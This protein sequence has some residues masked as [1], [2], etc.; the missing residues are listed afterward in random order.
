MNGRTIDLL[1]L[2]MNA[3]ILV[4]LTNFH[5]REDGPRK[6]EVSFGEHPEGEGWIRSDT[7]TGTYCGDRHDATTGEMKIFKVRLREP[8]KMADISGHY[9]TINPAMIVSIKVLRN[10]LPTLLDELSHSLSG[11][12]GASLDN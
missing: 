4:T 6:V 3:D 9:L 10:G 7:I 11:V 1:G 12:S 2:N 5:Y 8:F